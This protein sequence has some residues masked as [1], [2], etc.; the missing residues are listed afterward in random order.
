MTGVMGVLRR[1]GTALRP[2]ARGWRIGAVIAV[3]LLVALASVVRFHPAGV[4]GGGGGGKG[5][6][7]AGT[8]DGSSGKDSS[9][10]S[11]NG[12]GNQPNGIAGAAGG[13]SPS[14]KAGGGATGGGHSSPT[15]SIAMPTPSDGVYGTADVKLSNCAGGYEPNTQCAVYYHGVYELASHP[16]GKLIVEVLIDGAV[17]KQDT[18][19]APSGAH[20]FG[21]TIKFNVPEHAKKIVY[22]SVLEDSNGKVLVTSPPQN[23]YGYG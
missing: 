9:G 22:Q 14:P 16:S 18:F 20:R 5:P 7:L 21:D 4:L 1:T 23:T 11:G 15:P 10:A 6:A 3:V 8:G 13:Q 19:V 17:A 2:A 12:T